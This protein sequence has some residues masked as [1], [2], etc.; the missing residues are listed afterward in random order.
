MKLKKWLAP[1]LALTLDRLSA[2][3][4]RPLRR[5]RLPLPAARSPLRATW[6]ISRIRAPW[7]P[8]PTSPPWN[9]QDERSRIG[10]DGTWPRAVRKSHVEVQ[11]QVIE[12]DSK[13]WSPT[14]EDR[15]CLERDD[16]HQRSPQLHGVH[17][18][19]RH[20][21]PGG[22][23]ETRTLW[24]G[25]AD[26]ESPCDLSPSRWEFRPAG[27]ETAADKGFKANAVPLGRRPDGVWPPARPTP[28][29]SI[30]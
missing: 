21:R 7:W 23:D 13:P 9:Y 16:T 2:A 8:S 20:Q 15:L 12:W 19:L 1:A 28:A 18:R 29:S 11:F 24:T 22:G 27:E 30:C 26:E 14:Q 5:G 10:F 3:C 4:P 17:Q 6:P 25:T